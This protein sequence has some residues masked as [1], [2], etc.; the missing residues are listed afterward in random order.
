M[1]ARLSNGSFAG[2]EEGWTEGDHWAYT[3]NVMHD[4][5]GLIELMGGADKFVDF[6]D[7][8]FAGDHNLHT[9]EPSHHIPYLYAWAAPHRAQEW[10][11]SL[12]RSEYN[13]TDIGLSGV[14]FNCWSPSTSWGSDSNSLSSDHP[15]YL[16]FSFSF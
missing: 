8:H 4:V 13:H 15:F 14:S 2:P 16:S 5:P 12:G 1:E 6:I 7:R 11:R 3:L 10:V 9:N